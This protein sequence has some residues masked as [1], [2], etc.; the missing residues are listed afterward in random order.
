LTKMAAL[1]MAFTAGLLMSIQ[2][3]IN[4][5]LGRRIGVFESALISFLVGTSALVVIVIF[6]G[7]GNL[8]EVR[9]VPWYYLTGGLMGVF[10]VTTMILIIPKLGSGVGAITL[11]S[12][13]M[14][15]AMIIDHYGLLGVAQTPIGPNRIVGIVLLFISMRFIIGKF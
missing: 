9:N 10:V 3:A 4:A 14:L 13:Q 2:P 5:G 6:L 8:A 11:L 7:K 1:V 12:A 15:M